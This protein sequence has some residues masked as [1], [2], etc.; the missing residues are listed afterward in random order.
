MNNKVKFLRGTSDEYVA[1]TKDSDTIYF[2]TDDGKLY[3]GDKKILG[4]ASIDI[5]SKLSDTSENPVQN[6]VI[7]AELDKKAN[8]VETATVTLSADSWIGNEQT[9]S[10]SIV[11]SDCVVMISPVPSSQDEY[12][13][14]GIK[15]TSPSDGS[16]SF[17]CS[18]TPSSNIDVNVVTI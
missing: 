2:T 16:L 7:K 12:S 14:C 3:I 5:D 4:G 13:F 17:I 8:T 10:A 9:V 6:K 11:T 18:S 15:C 1:T